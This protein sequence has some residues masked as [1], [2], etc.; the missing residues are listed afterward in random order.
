MR[1][2]VCIVL[3][4]LLTVLAACK[5]ESTEKIRESPIAALSSQKE[6]VQLKF[7]SKNNAQQLLKDIECHIYDDRIV[8]CIPYLSTNKSLIATFTINGAKVTVNGVQQMTGAT[9]NTYDR[10][11]IFKVTAADGTTKD[12][13][14]TLYAFTGL[15][16]FYLETEAPVV[17][18]DDYVKGKITID[19]NSRYEQTAVTSAQMEMRGRGNST[20]E[21]AKKPYRI[22]LAAKT[23]LLGMPAAKKWVLLA[24][25]ADKTLMRNYLALETA[26]RFDAAFTPRARYVEVILNGEYLG[27]YLL[28]DQIEI[29][30][31]RINI[32][33]LKENATDIT[34]GYLLEVDE[35]L[36]EPF[37][38]RS[39]LQVAFTIK[40][41]EN[42]TTPQF[43][44]IKSYVQQIESALYSP[45]FTDTATGYPKYI[46]T[47][48]FINWYLV[49]ELMKNNDAVFFSSVFM[50]KAPNA[51]LSIGPVWDFDLAVG[52]ANYNGNNDP[53]GWWVKQSVWINRLFDDPA[54]V[55]KVK[56]RW[57]LLKG[58]Q[59]NSL[60]TFINETGVYL[61]YSQKENFNKWDVLYNYTWPNPVALGSYESEVQH[62]KDWLSQRITWM[63]TEINKL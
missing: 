48:T 3:I 57:N 59:V 47:E 15:P 54:F 4:A 34:G 13:T 31:T 16:I 52:N 61:K 1:K 8:G 28:T 30:E 20:W 23:A 39:L 32:P 46:N 26:R 12:Y 36:D 29:G 33:E 11:L 21:M 22:K 42:I 50:Y 25:F 14:V 19:A 35:R 38:F 41:P 17:S 24:N 5:K 55:K 63:D 62:M 53:R 27:N 44:Y 6:I 7:E 18:K 40:S 56:D 2:T 49:N 45:N 58:T 51:K 10:P 60:Y 37:W 43:N 9:I